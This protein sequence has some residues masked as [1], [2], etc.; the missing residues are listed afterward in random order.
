MLHNTIKTSVIQNRKVITIRDL[1]QMNWIKYNL[2]RFI[3]YL[4][5][6]AVKLFH[7]TKHANSKP[8]KGNHAHKIAVPPQSGEQDKASNNMQTYVMNKGKHFFPNVTHNRNLQ[9][10]KEML[11]IY[12]VNILKHYS[13]YS[14]SLH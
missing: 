5:L 14:A 12:M 1:E 11:N 9:V 13:L 10:E 8:P 6:S 3:Q 4:R 2:Q 7:T